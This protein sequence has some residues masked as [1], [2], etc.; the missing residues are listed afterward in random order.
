MYLRTTTS[1]STNRIRLNYADLNNGPKP[2]IV[3]WSISKL[4]FIPD[5]LQ[6]QV[7]RAKDKNGILNCTRQWGKSTVAAAMAVYMCLFEPDS[8][9]LIISTTEKQSG[10]LVRKARQFL[11]KLN[12]YPKKDKAHRL[13]IELRN[14]SRILVVPDSE[15]STRGYSGVKLLLVDEAARVSDE[16]YAA[17][18]P[19]LAVSGGKTWM[20]STPN[21]K[22]GFFFER[23][24]SLIVEPDEDWASVSVTAEQCPRIPQDWLA[25]ERS[26]VS[27]NWFAQE[28]LCVFT[29]SQGAVFPHAAI[30]A[31]LSKDCEP[32]R[33]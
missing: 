32:L 24:Q 18:R 4:G 27:S 10:E 8:L 28:F 1:P 6:A 3:E 26:K 14:G 31:A 15:A 33:L 21:G 13:S 12:L 23:W 29:E 17:L 7:L 20:L 9:I 22:R 16:A 5:N 30:Q 11:Y 2:D 19:C 25:K